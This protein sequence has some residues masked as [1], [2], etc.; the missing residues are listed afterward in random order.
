MPLTRNFSALMLRRRYNLG[1]GTQAKRMT[2]APTTPDEPNGSITQ[3]LA[4]IS[5]GNREAEVQLIQQLYGELRRLAAHYMRAE[6]R[7]HTLQPTALVNEAYA[8]LLGQPQLPWQS[9]AHFFATASQLMHHILVDHARANRAEKRGGARSQVT[10]DDAMIQ[11][12]DRTIDILAL[13]EALER[14]ALVDARQ[15]RAVELH[16]FGGLNFAEIALILNVAER[17]VKRDWKMAR[18]WLKGELSR[19]P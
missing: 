16:F 6:R 2:G 17:T 11:S 13:H 12:Q 15:A 9:R 7:N 14:L 3:L 10:L 8:R 4:Q 18:D 1:T 5:A 19:K